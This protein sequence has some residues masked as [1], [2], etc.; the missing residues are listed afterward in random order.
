MEIFWCGSILN[1]QG[2]QTYRGETP[3]ASQWSKGLLMGLQHNNIKVTGFAPVWDSLFPKG[4]LFPGDE[5]SLDMEI[6]QLHVPYINLPTLRTRTVA[7]SL[8]KAISKK[9]KEGVRPAAI[10]NYNTYP[11]YCL[12]LKALVKKYEFIKWV[13]VVLD[14][15][16]PTIDNWAKFRKDTDCSQGSIFL[17]WWGYENAPIS[18]KLHLDGGWSGEL[19]VNKFSNE[20]VFLYAGKLADYGG[21]NEI[22]NS[23][24]DFSHD[25]VYF[26]FY[27]KGNN[28]KLNALAAV[29]HRVRIKGFVED[30]VLDQAC[31]EATAFLS[32]RDI[33][34]QGTRMIFPSK[35]LFYLK[36]RKP[37]LSPMLPGLSPEYSN[38]L[39]Q[40]KDTSSVGWVEAMK[41]VLNLSKQE[42]S[43]LADRI[44]IFI[45]QKR[46]E[47]QASRLVEFIKEL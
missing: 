5:Q 45:S 9:I 30:D 20:K 13:N 6:P 11:H 14:L 26:D 34:F 3:A 37:V 33:S 8:E 28:E 38:V 2:L 42:L 29:D 10:L 19:P 39:F 44:G 21:I 32:P 18:N 47:Q 41:S 16:D 4:K 1:F 15:D 17:S 31:R 46:W 23:I 27:G 12:A 7:F 35:L 25:G 22:I 36:Y 24:K 40:P 43:N